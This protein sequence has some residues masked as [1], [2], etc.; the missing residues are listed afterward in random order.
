MSNSR[1]RVD[2]TPKRFMRSALGYDSE[3][4]LQNLQFNKINHFKIYNK[5]T[6]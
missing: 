3:G 5:V 6:Q 4:K 2:F 1:T